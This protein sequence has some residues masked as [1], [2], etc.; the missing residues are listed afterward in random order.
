MNCYSLVLFNQ[1]NYIVKKSNSK[2]VSIS[3]WNNVNDL[4]TPCGGIISMTHNGD[5]TFLSLGSTIDSTLK[6]KDFAAAQISKKVLPSIDI[7]S[8][9]LLHKNDNEKVNKQAIP[10]G[11]WLS[12]IFDSSTENIPPISVLYDGYMSNL[13]LAKQSTSEPFDQSF[14]VGTNN[15]IDV[16]GIDD[17]S[18]NENTNTGT[19]KK[20]VND[21]VQTRNRKNIPNADD[22]G[23]DDDL[24]EALHNSVQSIFKPNSAP[25]VTSL[26]RRSRSNSATSEINDK[27]KN[28]PATKKSTPTSKPRS[29]STT[30]DKSLKARSNSITSGSRPRSDSFNQVSPPVNAPPLVKF[31]LQV[32]R[33]QELT[34]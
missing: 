7:D 31:K 27:A 10:K 34:L 3:F 8:G 33:D 19:K 29:D 4:Y 14:S 15:K 9:T 26:G 12:R 32:H 13:L 5:M 21:I 23:F 20:Q 6:M 18:D 17:D 25:Q 1:L 16:V 24:L 30:S 2:I 28:T 11:G 22:E